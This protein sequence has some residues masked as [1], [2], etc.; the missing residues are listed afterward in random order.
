MKTK[1]LG[2]SQV[3]AAFATVLALSGGT[4]QAVTC[5]VPSLVPFYPTIQSAVND[6]S[7]NPINVAAGTYAENVTIPIARSSLILNG[8]QAGNPVAGR[9][10]AVGE[11]TITG[12]GLSSPDFTIHA[13]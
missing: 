4:A 10:F 1:F 3:V 12:T 8:A 11:S 13:A 2:C 5:N 9:T 6:P 7:C